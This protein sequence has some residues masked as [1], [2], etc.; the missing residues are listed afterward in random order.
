MTVVAAPRVKTRIGRAVSGDARFR[1][2][3]VDRELAGKTSLT[4]QLALAV[5]GRRFAEDEWAVM[6]A[7]AAACL[8]ADPRIWPI[9]AAALGASHG[10]LIPGVAMAQLVFDSD[11]IGPM[12]IIQAAEMLLLLVDEAGGD[13]RDLDAVE[14][15]ARQ[16][17]A[18]GR[19]LVGFG[20]P[21]RA[22][23]ERLATLERTMATLGRDERPY[24]LV[25]RGLGRVVT[26]HKGVPANASLGVSAVFL[27]LEIAPSAMGALILGLLAPNYIGV[28]AESAESASTV[29]QSLPPACVRY[30]GPPPRLSP[31]ALAAQASERATKPSG[32]AG[33]GSAPE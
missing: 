30:T 8:A 14:R 26:Q 27:D 5:T 9:K 4:A 10:R 20:T 17:V 24:W 7:V 33:S 23:D 6:D 16:W 21:F 28:A 32:D 25:A 1:G 12:A 13:P 29:L 11:V 2:C 15:V 3:S 22:F 31:R 18:E 19:R